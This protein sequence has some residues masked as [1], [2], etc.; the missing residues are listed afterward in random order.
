MHAVTENPLADVHR[1][2][3][4]A[5]DALVAAAGCGAGD[6]EL[7]SAV[8]ICESLTR[9]LDQLAVSAIA[10]LSRRGTFAER[11]YRTAAGALSD[12]VGWDRFESRRRV[13]AA[14]QVCPRIGLDGT[15]LPAR[16]A[17]TTAV[18]AAGGCGLRHVEVIA[19]VLGSPAA[20]RISPEAWAGVEAELADKAPMY[21]PHDLQ[22][23]GTALVELLDQDG[24]EPDDRDP[25]PVNE[26]HLH[27][28]S[29]GNGGTLKGTFE[30]AALFDAIATL[31]DAKSKPLTGDDDRTA[32]QR[33][34]DALA[35]VCGYVLDHGDVGECGG[36]RP[37]LNVIVRLEDLENRCRSA[38][39]DF[40][41]GLMPESLR[42]LAC[43]AAVVPIVLNGKGQP[44][45]VGRVTRTIPDGLR[46]AVA[47]RDLGC[48]HPGCNRPPS[49]CEV[50]HI[51]PWEDGGE[52]KL[53]NC[54][55]LCRVHHRLLH[56]R[57]GWRVRIRDGL[58]EF[59]PP[60]WI[61]PERRARRRALPQ[62]VA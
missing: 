52:T 7:L 38:L 21:S 19:K 4:E 55:M 5:V 48:A 56:R 13:S 53:S 9:R 54:V 51:R 58:P 47:A 31:I 28:R 26:L 57:S 59:I 42:M 25:D 22:A 2:S 44:L 8:T 6:G 35:E 3:S 46:R 49:W 12:L 17:A 45:D 36:Q 43:D 23:H 29:D 16:L 39:L 15:V 37:H 24:A 1:L 20:G 61:D 50:H 33:Q 32:P 34:A 18:F 40:G 10:E 27:R 14:E 60:A 11:G 62:L 41:G 30:D